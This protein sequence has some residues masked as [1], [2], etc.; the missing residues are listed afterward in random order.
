MKAQNK[1]I[2]DAVP[3]QFVRLT[4]RSPTEPYWFFL[5]RPVGRFHI[6]MAKMTVKQSQN[7]AWQRHSRSYQLYGPPM[8]PSAHDLA[9]YW[10]SANEWIQKRGAPRVLLLGV[11]P[12][13]YNLPW[14]KGTDFMAVDR[15]QAMIDA[16]WPGPKNS[17]LRADWLSLNLPDGSRDIVLCD[18]GLH[19]L[20][21]PQGQHR[22]IRLLRSILS[23]G[24]LCIFRLYIL[25]SQRETPDAV[26]QDL[27]DGRIGNLDTL[28]L[29]LSMSMHNTA[30]EGVEAGQVY[31]ALIKAAPDLEKLAV[32]IE[33]PIE[34]MLLINDY[35]DMEYRFYWLTVEQVIDLFCGDP[36]G[37]RVHRLKTP[38]YE[39]G[40][41]C[42]TIAL[43][44]CS[45]EKGIE[46][47]SV[48]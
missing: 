11:T 31:G 3:P 43:Q 44:C 21:Y 13:L 33:W 35:K 38:S 4:D 39:L 17:V 25:P 30:E 1:G 19:L 22:L 5:G 15:T 41:R 45:R 6:N 48:D 16:A 7:D 46:N 32:K 27:L 26:I 8:R 47:P 2:I 36:G 29:R 14:P 23:D 20:E 42:P 40:Q 10:D 28:K 37:F 12:E 34:R 24:G 9:F 18:G